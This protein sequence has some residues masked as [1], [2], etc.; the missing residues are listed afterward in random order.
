MIC[1]G[2]VAAQRRWLCGQRKR[3]ATS[4]RPWALHPAQRRPSSAPGR[5]CTAPA[6]ANC[7]AV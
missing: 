5:S 4:D 1:S 3:C 6:G 2:K 7:R